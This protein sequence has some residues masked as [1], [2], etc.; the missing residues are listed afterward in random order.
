MFNHFSCYAILM[1]IINPNFIKLV[2][3]QTGFSLSDQ[4]QDDCREKNYVSKEKLYL[5]IRLQLCCF[6]VLLIY[7]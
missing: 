2:C 3:K 1:S 5:L 7:I 6:Q 4:I